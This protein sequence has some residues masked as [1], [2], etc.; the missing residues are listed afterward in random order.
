MLRDE[1]MAMDPEEESWSVEIE[2][3]KVQT[4]WLEYLRI[5]PQNVEIYSN[6]AKRY[7]RKHKSK[8]L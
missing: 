5:D 1:I 4:K 7:A 3:Q 6:W 2:N 8:G